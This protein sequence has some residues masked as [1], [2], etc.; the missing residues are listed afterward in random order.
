MKNRML[1]L[2]RLLLLSSPWWVSVVQA[3]ETSV[4]GF[5]IEVPALVLSGVRFPLEIVAVD[6]DGT[7]V[8]SY[9]GEPRILEETISAR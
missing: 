7:P 1:H 2:F 9:E 3:Q 8:A 6:A 4:A 5:E